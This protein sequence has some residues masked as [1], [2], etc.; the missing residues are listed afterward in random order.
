MDISTQTAFVE[1]VVALTNAERARFGLAPLTMDSQLSQAAQNHSVDMALNDF[2]GHI[3]SNGSTLTNRLLALG[4]QFQ[5]A[6]DNVAAGYMSPGEVVQ[7]WMESPSHRANILNPNLKDIGVGYYY[8]ASD[9]GAVNYY[10]Y[11][12]QVFGIRVPGTEPAAPTPMPTPIPEPALE[13]APVI[14]S[15][16]EPIPEPAPTPEPVPTPAPAPTPGADGEPS[17]PEPAP[18][19]SEGAGEP[20]TSVPADPVNANQGSQPEP[21]A[22]SGDE[23]SLPEPGNEPSIPSN[24]SKGLPP[25]VSSGET[26]STP[27]PTTDADGAETPTTPDINQRLVGD[28]FDNILQAGSGNDLI[29]GNLGDDQLYG[30]DGDDVLRGDLDSR[31]AGGTSGGDDLL[32]GGNGND[33]LGGKGGN[34][35]LYGGAGDDLLWGDDGD[36]LLRGGL[37]HDVLTGDNFSG[38]QGRD[39]FVLAIAEGTDTIT[40]FAIGIDLIGL[41]DGL[42]FGALSLS[43]NTIKVGEETLAVLNGVDTSLLTE[44]SFVTI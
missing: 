11:W 25:Q 1:Q 8:L 33:R 32:Y 38:G 6:A 3:G 24:D 42:S 14:V 22:E 10:D 43:D 4:Y 17:G 26:D 7:G 2:F 34:D 23:S 21:P 39:T 41:A 5:T 19:P 29:I 28:R 20:P 9:T 40:D 31:D 30:G 16:P 15:D 27:P 13:P 37:G 18:L 35:Q 44:A 36:D 12:T